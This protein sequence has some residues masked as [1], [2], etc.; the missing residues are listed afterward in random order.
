M[1]TTS[2][3]H[4]AEERKAQ[5]EALHAS[6]LEQVEQLA[7][8]GQWRRFLDFARSFHPYSL[9]NVLL[10]LAQNPDATMVAGY[11]QWQAKGRQVRKNETAIKIFGHSTKKTSNDDEH[12]STQREEERTIHYFPVLSV[13]DIS[14]TD[15]I[16]GDRPGTGKPC[17]A[18]HRQRRPRSL[19]AA[20][21]IPSQRR[22]GRPPRT[23]D[24][25]QRVHRPR[26]PCRRHRLRSVTRAR[27]EDAH[28]RSRP[29]QTAT[30]R[31]RQRIPSTPRTH[32]SGSRVRRLHRR[33]PQRVRH[34]RVQHR[35]HHRMGRRRP[36][37]HPRDR[38]TRPPLRTNALPNDGRAERSKQLG[39]K[40]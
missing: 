20:H 2:T 18:P 11:R 30:H 28:P 17:P 35:L 1:N 6:I 7:Q 26:P 36:R 16:P 19:P 5:A 8:S 25:R 37:P 15:P 29:H 13:F 21:R 31:R 3:K 33:R 34:Q 38:S 32:G 40:R 22:V 23:A 14:Q 10:I 4:S 39:L 9:N 27:R 12:Q 24:P